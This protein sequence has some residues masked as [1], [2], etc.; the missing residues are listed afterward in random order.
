MDHELLK[1]FIALAKYKNFTKTAQQMNVVQSTVTS[2]LK[3]LEESLGEA[4]FVRTNKNVA[5]TSAGE[6]FLPYAKQIISIYNSALFK[7]KSLETFKDTLHIGVVHS[8]YDDHVQNMIV[9]YMKKNKDIAIKV[10]IEHSENLIPMI[11]DNQLDIAF[12]YL[13]TKS[14]KLICEPFKKD[15]IILVTGSNNK[16]AKKSIT[17]EELKTLPLLASGIL[18]ESFDHWFHSIIPENYIYPLDINIISN[19]VP[20]LEANLGYSF[21]IDASVENYIKEGL[22][23]KV[24]LKENTVPNMESYMII[25]KKRQNSE[26]VIRWL[27]N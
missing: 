4:L 21:M 7:M 1:T 12:T 18:T 15:K 20:F 17:N 11:E 27:S 14:P 5:L 6:T 8:L 2:R 9:N 19:V 25:N 24:S 23:K 16:L 3:H 10:T 26:A 13:S 22:L